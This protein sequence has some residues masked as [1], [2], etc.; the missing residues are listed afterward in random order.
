MNAI[1]TFNELKKTLPIYFEDRYSEIKTIYNLLSTD[2]PVTSNSRKI[3]LMDALGDMREWKGD[4]V[5]NT[6]K[7]SSYE[8][9]VKNYELTLGVKG[10]DIE[11]GSV[12]WYNIAAAALG[13]AAA[14]KPDKE[15]A[16]LIEAGI[17]TECIDGQYFFDTDHPYEGGVNQNLYTARPLSADTLQEM[18]NVMPKFMQAGGQDTVGYEADT[19]IVPVDLRW[20]AM[21]L[22]KS[23]QYPEE[24]TVTS[25]SAINV[26]MDANLNLIV[27][28]RLTSG[29]ATSTWY[30]ARL[31]DVIKPF[32][33]LNRKA[34][35]LVPPKDD[36]NTS[37]RMFMSNEVLYGV[38]G[39]FGIGYFDPLRIIRVEGV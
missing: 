7:E 20:K 19:L 24:S 38:D 37:D 21:E 33:F 9:L 22:L 4:R 13:E 17:T 28:S 15:L 25:G 23:T 3:A 39:R 32:A 34:P 8:I 12:S 14:T 27:D 2:I 16:K 1:D 18:L 36:P 5:I 29:G 30:V 31:G 26:L 6:L 10:T 11:D 35:V